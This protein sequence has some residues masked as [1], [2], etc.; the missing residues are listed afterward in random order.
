MERKRLLPFIQNEEYNFVINTDH[1]FPHYANS[2]THLSPRKSYTIF[3]NATFWSPLE[4]YTYKSTFK[5]SF[6]ISNY[7]NFE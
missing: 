1:E 3:L 6:F 7:L 4:L 5:N 2:T